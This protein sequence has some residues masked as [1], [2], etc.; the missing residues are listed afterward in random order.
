VSTV[1]Q[2]LCDTCLARS[3]VGARAAERPR[4]VLA[5]TIL[6]SSLAFVDGSVVNVALPAIARALKADAGALQWTINAYLLPLSAALLL[7]GAAGDRFGKRRVLLLGV[8]LFALTSLACA[9]SLDLEALLVARFLQGI[10]AAMLM[11]NSLA[12]L[13]ESYP[14]ESKGRAIGIWASSSAVAGAVGPVLGG[15]LIDLGNWRA[16]FL[17]NLPLAV[18]A[19]FL[20]L[21]FVPADRGERHQPLD[22]RGALLVTAGLAGI[23]WALTIGSGPHGWSPAAIAAGSVG[24]ALLLV[25][26]LQE[27]RQG[28]RA[29]IP[30][31]LFASRN[32]VAL[33][34]IT[35]LLYAGLSAL[36][37]LVPYV[38]LE[39]VGYSGTAAGGALLPV[40]IITSSLSPAAGSIADR[41]GARLPIAIGSVL[42]GVG[43]VMTLR[44]EATSAYWTGLLPAIFLV[45]VGLSAAVP[46]LTTAVLDSVAEQYTGA[47]SG[48]NSATARTGGLVATALLGSVLASHGDQLFRSFHVAMAISAFACWGA[49]LCALTLLRRRD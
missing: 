7:G 4:L 17:I 15:W 25:F 36:F 29:L 33:N 24:M 32:I 18:A 26:L 42:V 5:T 9:L 41:I 44:V 1:L 45:S 6:A 14:N 2:A 28:D 8:V 27:K 3:S 48:L 31:E 13:G 12:I 22:I 16:I 30:L 39:G 23:T 20:A 47:A 38:L 10:S 11:P 21:K 43:L 40:P 46:P 49:A 35:L 34:G 37:V 19:I